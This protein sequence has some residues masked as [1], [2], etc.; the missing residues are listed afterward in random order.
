ML[1]VLAIDIIEVSPPVIIMR[2]SDDVT[3]IQVRAQLTRKANI[4]KRE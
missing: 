4:T 3:F 2:E 1:P